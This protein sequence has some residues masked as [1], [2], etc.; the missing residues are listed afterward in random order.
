[1]MCQF[2]LL[3]AFFS[4]DVTTWADQS[5]ALV[6]FE[7]KRIVLDGKS[8][9]VEIADTDVKRE[10]GLMYRKHL[11]NGKGMLFTF[12]NPQVLV[13]W[14]K[15]T[16]IPLS[17]GFFD[18]D[19]KLLNTEDMYPAHETDDANLPRFSSSGQAA[20]ALEVPIGW[21][22]KH[23]VKPGAHFRFLHPKSSPDVK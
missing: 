8:L 15:N 14:M 7:K 4:F 18:V 3:F 17:I 2:L 1:M 13:F 6:H 5:P 16:E 23:K 9:Q 12:E 20:Y 10:R 22:T 21:F 11:E 19:Q